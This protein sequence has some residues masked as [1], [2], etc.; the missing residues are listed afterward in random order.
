[1]QTQSDVVLHG[2]NTGIIVPGQILEAAVQVNEQRYLLFLTDDVIFEESL[3]I[4][5][6]DIRDGV[7]EIVRLGNEYSSG[8]F[9]NLTV[10]GDS[11]SFSFIS[12]YIWTLKALET[13]RLPLPFFQDPQGVKRMSGLKKYIMISAAPV[14]ENF[15]CG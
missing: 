12:D 2:R 9:E 14:S 15:R 6:I 5:L 13:P 4:A 3:T 8:S 1:L 10:T 11:V 7:K